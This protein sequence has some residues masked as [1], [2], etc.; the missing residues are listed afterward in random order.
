MNS[1]ELLSSRGSRSLAWLNGSPVHC[2]GFRQAVIHLICGMHLEKPVI[3]GVWVDDCQVTSHHNGGPLGS[4][5]WR[6]CVPQDVVP[7][8]LAE[9][10]LSRQLESWRQGKHLNP[11]DVI[12]FAPKPG[13]VIHLVLEE[14][15]GD[16]VLG[17]TNVKMGVVGLHE[18]K[19]AYCQHIQRKH[20]LPELLQRCVAHDVTPKM[21]AVE[22]VE[23]LR[24]G[25]LVLPISVGGNAATPRMKVK[26]VEGPKLW[27]VSVCC[28]WICCIPDESID[29]VD[30]LLVRDERRSQLCENCCGCDKISKMIMMIVV[31]GIAKIVVPLATSIISIACTAHCSTPDLIVV[32]LLWRIVT[33][34]GTGRFVETSEALLQ[35]VDALLHLLMTRMEFFKEQTHHSHLLKAF[36]TE[37]VISSEHGESPA[38][39]S[40]AL[41]SLH[42]RKHFSCNLCPA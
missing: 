21:D 15:S 33:V 29:V 11:M 35:H 18:E 10:R 28:A 23:L 39:P 42:G 19:L 31:A 41:E 20:S 34:L 22:K 38:E 17:E 9:V 26:P 24:S 7:L 5:L 37:I 8:F 16:P 40:V 36:A 6:L 27:E 4:I 30:E 2:P 13:R 12:L 25:L 32:S 3:C 1:I 14:D